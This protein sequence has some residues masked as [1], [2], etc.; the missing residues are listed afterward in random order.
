MSWDRKMNKSSALGP[1]NTASNS[2][3][4]ETSLQEASVS[5]NKLSDINFN[6]TL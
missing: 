3:N 1:F 5:S 2:K 6:I 4:T